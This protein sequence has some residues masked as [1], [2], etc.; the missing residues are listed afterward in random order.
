MNFL[1]EQKRGLMKALIELY[2]YLISFMNIYLTFHGLAISLRV[3]SSAVAWPDVKFNNQQQGG[4][5]IERKL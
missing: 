5:L 3:D 4:K 2:R 1:Q